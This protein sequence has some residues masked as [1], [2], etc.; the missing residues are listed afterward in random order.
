MHHSHCPT[1]YQSRS[2][3]KAT[4]S[5]IGRATTTT[6]ATTTTVGRSSKEGN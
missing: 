6:A 3:P 5:A 2:D 1:H 4:D